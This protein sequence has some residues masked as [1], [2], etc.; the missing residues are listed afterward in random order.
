MRPS[1]HSFD[2]IKE[3]G[4]FVINLVP[5]TLAKTADFCGVYTGKKVDK[6][7]KCSLTREASSVVS[8]PSIAESPLSIECRVTDVIEMGSHDMFLADIVAVNVDEG[9]LDGDGK[10]CLDKAH[11]AA[12]AHGE[13]FSLGKKI[14]Y[15]G[16]STKASSPKK[17]KK[18]NTQGKGKGK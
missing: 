8:C 13:Y 18:K 3:S 10:L 6:F 7:E 15:F 14:G 4:E 1:R 16:F 11:L 12:F 2:I 5:A 17:H 9:L